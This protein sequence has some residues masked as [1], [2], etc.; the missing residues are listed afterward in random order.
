MR[1]ICVCLSLGCAFLL[2]GCG[3]DVAPPPPGASAVSDWASPPDLPA[4]PA[5]AEAPAA[6]PVELPYNTEEYARIVEAGFQSPLKAPLSTFSI[7]VD[8]ASYSN[9]RRMLLNHQ[10]PPAG[11][12]RI[13][14]LIN[15]FPYDYP[16]PDD[17][18][19]FAV[20]SEVATCPWAPEHRLLRIGIQGKVI[21]AEE[22]P[23]CN[24]V[25]LIDT[26]GSMAAEEKLP[27]VQRAL[28]ELVSELDERDRISVVTYASGSGVALAPTAANRKHEIISAIE[29][30][31][32]QGATNGSAGIETAYAQ[33][34]RN[35]D[36]QG[37]N[38]VIICTDGDFNVGNSSADELVRLIESKRDAGIA[39]SVLGFG[40]GNYKDDRMEQLADHGNGNYA[41][42]DTFAEARK[43]LIT[44]LTGTLMTIAKDVKI[45]VE[46]NPSLVGAYRLVGYENRRLAAE[47]FLDD[48]K[49][50]GDIGAGHSVTALYEIIPV[51]QA[52]EAAGAVPPLR[53]QNESQLSADA[54]SSELLTLRLRYKN[55]QNE[56]A[57]SIEFRG[58]DLG[59]DFTS[60]S[61]EFHFIAAVAAFG[62]HL[63]NSEFEG[64]TNWHDIRQWAEMGLGEDREGYR[65]E[66]LQLIQ[67]AQS[68]RQRDS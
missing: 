36:P 25:F 68:Q 15:Y 17:G 62:L 26:S 34:A 53:Y 13:E 6:L 57:S 18:R 3:S 31:S 63:R 48:R 67:L 43:V 11:A 50:A 5:T 8:T 66:F 20:N 47:D 29:H 7:D 46:F 2:G 41:Y 64:K 44:Q 51:G 19:P 33:A 54:E 30:L 28:S 16:L 23:P 60:A 35:F 4:S 52:V 37:I 27:L 1:A 61:G 24:L 40:M 45:Q 32:A 42:I 56:E 39:L 9:V 55:P 14:E 59:L 22:R 38:R 10:S 58:Y 49:D 65:H 12:V 21:E